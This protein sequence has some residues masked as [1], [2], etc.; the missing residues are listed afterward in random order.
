MRWFFALAFIVAPLSSGCG[1]LGDD[2]Q[3]P[4]RGELTVAEAKS[5]QDFALYYLGDEF[6]RQALNA[7]DRTLTERY[8]GGPPGPFEPRLTQIR[9]LHTGE[10]R[11]LSVS[12]RDSDLATL[13]AKP[14][15]LLPDA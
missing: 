6:E 10:R 3:E 2:E 1:S 11:R 7:I 14:R 5:F 8:A 12:A 15:Q 9:R 13:R 4:G